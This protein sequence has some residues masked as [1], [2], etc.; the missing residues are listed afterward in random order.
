MVSG[1]FLL[2]CPESNLPMKICGTPQLLN[3]QNFAKGEEIEKST[4]LWTTK[5]WL[6]CEPA[7]DFYDDQGATEAC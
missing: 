5:L 6:S 3:S 4:L 2:F 1:F 7:A